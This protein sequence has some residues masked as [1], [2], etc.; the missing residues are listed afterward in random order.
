MKWPVLPTLLDPSSSAALGILA[1]YKSKGARRWKLTRA[2]AWDAGPSTLCRIS[3]GRHRA[4][5]WPT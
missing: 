2:T 5:S 1:A 4:G 3:A